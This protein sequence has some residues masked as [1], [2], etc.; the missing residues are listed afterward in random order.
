[1]LSPPRRLRRLKTDILVVCSIC[2]WESAVL[3]TEQTWPPSE[4]HADF[5]VS[6]LRRASCAELHRYFTQPA[7]CFAVSDPRSL[8]A[9]ICMIIRTGG[10]ESAA[11]STH[12]RHVTRLH[13]C[14]AS[15]AYQANVTQ[16]STNT[17]ATRYT[18]DISSL[19]KTAC[20]PPCNCINS[21]VW[22]DKASSEQ[23]RPDQLSSTRMSPS[24]LAS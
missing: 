4:T 2:L 17:Y 12:N 20:T 10:S 16:R 21:I 22:P 14:E 24:G 8:G 18:D 5:Y 13:A 19:C 7:T 3:L 9:T 23:L 1:M 11:N 15:V 6:A